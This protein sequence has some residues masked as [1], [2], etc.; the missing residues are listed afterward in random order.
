MLFCWKLAQDFPNPDCQLP[1]GKDCN[2]QGNYVVLL[3]L[4]PRFSIQI[5]NYSEEKDC[6]LQG[7][8]ENWRFD[9]AKLYNDASTQILHLLASI[10][11]KGQKLFKN[12]DCTATPSQEIIALPKTLW[13]SAHNSSWK[14]TLYISSTIASIRWILFPHK[15]SGIKSWF[16]LPTILNSTTSFL[17]VYLMISMTKQ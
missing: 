12:I 7:K 10:F 1:R 14:W 9:T 15:R 16:C 13:D 17:N 5:V 2:L 11:D 8:L 4:G 6:N 3:V